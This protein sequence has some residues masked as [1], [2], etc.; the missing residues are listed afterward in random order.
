MRDTKAVVERHRRSQAEA[1][2][3]VRDF[4]QSGLSRK[5]FCSANGVGVHTLDYY[6]HRKRTRGAAPAGQDL[7]PVDLISAPCMRGGLRVELVNGR[8]IVVEGGF[9][10]S[11]LRRLI[12]VLE[13]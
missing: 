4:E 3:L 10:A 1:E 6:R 9:D 5:A 8:R 12:S 7:L 11:V 13:G 2:S